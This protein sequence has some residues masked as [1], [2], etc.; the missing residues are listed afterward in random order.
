MMQQ[1]YK[2]AGI[3]ESWGKQIV[4]VLQDVGLEYLRTTYDA[5][6]LNTPAK[7]S[8]PIHFYTLHLAWDDKRTEWIPQP[9]GIVSTDLEGVRKILAGGTSEEYITLDGFIANI[10]RRIV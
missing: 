3:T 10:R 6:G 1:V 7:E 5:S 9:A 4:F 2:K 8:D